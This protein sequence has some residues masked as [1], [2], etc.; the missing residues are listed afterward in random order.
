MNIVL[1]I[2]KM[3]GGLAIFLY[4]MEIMG[5]GL[6]QSSGDALKMAPA[7]AGKLLPSKDAIIGK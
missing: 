2:I 7:E 3:L 4:G 1:T 6:K 5:D